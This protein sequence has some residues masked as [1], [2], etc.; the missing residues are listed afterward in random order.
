MLRKKKLYITD[1]LDLKSIFFR[2]DETATEK[3]INVL[4]SQ[5]SFNDYFLECPPV[6]LESFSKT[7]FEFVIVD[8]QNQLKG[9]K[10]D[11]HAF[12]EHFHEKNPMEICSVAFNNLGND[13]KLITPCPFDQGPN[14]C[15]ESYGHLAS[16]MKK[17]PSFQVRKFWKD[18]AFHFIK[19]VH[20]KGHEYVWLSTAGQ[21]IS[22]L[23]V[24]L[25][26][27]PKY[28]QTKEYKNWP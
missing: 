10:V 9:R 7:P 13:A 15:H 27:R 26:S 24:R 17:G 1:I 14:K 2:R 28:Y 12:S 5:I 21:G 6:N 8:A 22:W 20:I 23:H 16:F 3:F 25:D 18:V 19:Q 11:S 4:Q